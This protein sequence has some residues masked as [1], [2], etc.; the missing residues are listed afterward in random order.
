M[1]IDKLKS[2]LIQAHNNGD[3]QAAQLFAS[4]IK[5][6]Q[7]KLEDLTLG[8]Q[9]VNEMNA[10]MRFVGGMKSSVD[11]AR[12]GIEDL[13]RKI[14][15]MEENPNMK[16]DLELGKLF[17]Q[18][19]GTA[20]K[21]GDFTGEAL[22]Y[23]VASAFAPAGLLGAALTQGA[24]GAAVTPGDVGDR[25]E[26]AAWAAGGEGAGR[27][28]G[29]ALE[30][31]ARPIIPTKE[32]QNLIDRGILPTPGAAAGGV[33]KTIEDRATSIP[34][35]GD[36]INMGRR[37]AIRQGNVA[38]LNYGNT[39]EKVMQH[40][41]EGFAARD[42]AIDNQFRS[43]L[44]GV[45]FDI[46]DPAFVQGV[47]A[48]IRKNNLTADGISQVEH[49]LNEIRRNHNFPQVTNPNPGG[50]VGQAA[51]APGTALATRSPNAVG[52]VLD[53]AQPQPQPR[54]WLNGEATQDLIESLRSRG[55]R[56]NSAYGNPYAQDVG[57]TFHDINKLVLENAEKQ[58]F[59]LPESIAKWK[60]ARG[61]YAAY[62]PAMEAAN[63]PVT[64]R[65][66]GIFT[67]IQ[68]QRE[69]L[70]NMKRNG[71]SGMARRGESDQL[72]FANDMT[73]V[74]GSSYPDSG[75]AGRLLLAGL[76]TGSLGGTD[77]L[78]AGGTLGA[79]GLAMNTRAGRK[80]LLGQYGKQIP[81]AEAL[82]RNAKYMGAAGAAAGANINSSKDKE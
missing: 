19:S 59:S 52:Q 15:G 29:K 31:I 5:D 44:Q 58:G 12:Y 78:A 54:Q 42:A 63:S 60:D 61:Q 53:H 50:G 38:A 8:G 55:Q 33:F 80:Y 9:N 7:S 17:S 67:P 66:D 64:S 39:G 13:G 25:L 69:V 45:G 51:G 30:K 23:A 37:D 11:R 46:N 62:K 48:A 70:K 40:G 6:T 1:D 10:G 57:R 4:K 82:R 72:R 71:Q 41:F 3:E 32:A 75:T 18:N 35:L 47:E 22:P 2:A 27:F 77:G 65:N 20:G 21:I 28:L 49:F 16:R 56:F 81:I 24:V 36:A 73:K 26:G 34:G 76:A 79:L 14:L 43:A 68:Y 74:L